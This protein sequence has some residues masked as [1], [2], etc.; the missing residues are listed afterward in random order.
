MKNQALRFLFFFAMIF[1]MLI[2]STIAHA[3]GI[4]YVKPDG[5][6]DCSSW[7]NSCN[8]Q[9]ALT[10]AASGNEIWVAA[11]TYKPTAGSDRSATFQLVNDVAVYGGFAGTETAR[12]ERNPVTNITILSGDLNGDDV[13]FT[14]NSENVYHVVTGV[15]GATLDGFTIIGGNANANDVMN[16]DGNGGGMLNY[17]ATSPTLTNLIFS[18]NATAYYGGGMLNWNSSN[19]TLTDVSF[20]GNS[21]GSDGGGMFNWNSSSPTLMNVTFSG[22]SAIVGGGMYN[23]IASNPILINVTFNGNSATSLR[24]GGMYNYQSS[25]TL[26]NVTFSGNS[27]LTT[28]GGMYNEAGSNPTVRNTIFWGNTA[29]GGGAQIYN[30]SSSPSISDSVVQGGYA[31]TNII[32]TDPLLGPLGNYGSFTQTIPLLVGSSA[33]DT[34]NDAVCPATDQRGVTRQHGAHCDIGAYEVNL[35][36][37]NLPL[38]MR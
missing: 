3:A 14:N 6:S 8:L 34:G 29:P 25:P 32:T 31:G 35:F 11:G 4:L 20:I 18:G 22:N 9:S 37:I 23:Y 38:M 28:G 21:A 16:P 2:P 13:G 12:G 30:V 27:A 36:S 17:S 24:G 7:A 15:T 10:G 26:T 5:T 19:P 33:I 1:S